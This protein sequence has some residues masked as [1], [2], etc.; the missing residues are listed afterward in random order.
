MMMGE[1]HLKTKENKTG[2]FHK[3]TISKKKPPKQA[4]FTFMMAEE[5]KQE[6]T[7][8]MQ[9]VTRKI[10]QK[11]GSIDDLTE[12]QR[13]GAIHQVYAELLQEQE[14]KGLKVFSNVNQAFHYFVHEYYPSKVKTKGA[15]IEKGLPDVIYKY[16]KNKPVG[17]K[18]KEEIL[19]KYKF[20][21]NINGKV[22]KMLMNLAD[23]E[24][25]KK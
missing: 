24:K 8:L 3:S 4:K 18:K 15:Q 25:E 2:K 19:L 20:N 1:K 6:F 5:E 9:E 13:E 23:S 14:E 21:I 11:Y 17:E 10:I 22:S 7:H 16:K 12:Q